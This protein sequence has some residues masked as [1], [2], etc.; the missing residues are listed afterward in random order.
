MYGFTN[1][2]GTVMRRHTNQQV[3]FAYAD[4]LANEI[5]RKNAAFVQTSPL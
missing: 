2:L 4:Q 1:R 3:H 5:I